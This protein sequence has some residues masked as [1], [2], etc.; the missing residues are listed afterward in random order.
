L[1]DTLKEN[2]VE[3]VYTSKET[4]QTNYIIKLDHENISR[5]GLSVEQI[6][7]SIYNMFD[8]DYV[9]IYHDEKTKQPINLYMSLDK[10]QKNSLDI[11]NQIYFTNSEGKKIFLSEISKLIPTETDHT[12]YSDDRLPTVYIYGEM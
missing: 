2:E 3:D 7:Y 5:L 4:Y 10:N 8:G 9:S 1:Q 11:F 6:A 12:V